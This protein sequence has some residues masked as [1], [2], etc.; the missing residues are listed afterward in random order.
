MVKLTEKE[1]EARKRV[2]L[3]LDVP[4]VQKALDLAEELSDF[5]GTFKVGKELHTAAGNEGVSIIREI[6]DRGGNTFLDL[7]LHDTPKTV[8]GASRQAAVRGV[9]VFNIHI[10]GGEA[11]CKKAL[12]GAY[13]GAKE[14]GIERPMVIG[15]TELTSVDD[16]DLEAQHLNI[17]YD[18]LVKRRTLLAREW[19]LDGIV[20]PASKAGE[21]ER[22]GYDFLKLT[23]G[24]EWGGKKGEG[25]KQLYTPDKAVIDC[26]NSI[27]VIGSAITKAED[28]RA[29]A[30]EI[31]R[32][33]ATHL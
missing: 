16:K 28:R 33:M 17:T 8:Y 5:V 13:D 7:K 30:Y 10:A 32:A 14:R 6:L 1:Q 26:S 12:Q 22:M 19:G 25:Q 24:I 21:L 15:V 20:C 2:C 27:L 31:L 4:T 9:Y 29:T 11:M 23:P 3:A 18:K